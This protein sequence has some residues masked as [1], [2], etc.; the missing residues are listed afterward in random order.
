MLVVVSGL[1]LA[2]A[3]LKNVRRFAEMKKSHKWITITHDGTHIDR[4]V[5]IDEKGV[6]VV[7]INGQICELD[8]CI[9]HYDRVDVW[10]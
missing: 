3:W 2:T 8:W 7:K 5:W 9:L 4:R 10:S 1:I 6:E